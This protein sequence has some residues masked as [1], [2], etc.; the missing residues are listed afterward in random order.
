MVVRGGPGQAWH[1]EGGGRRGE[2]GESLGSS[3]ASARSRTRAVKVKLPTKV[4]MPRPARGA[5]SLAGCGAGIS[6][7]QAECGARAAGA[8][9]GRRSSRGWAGAEEV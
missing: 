2:V 9:A 1:A 8:F 3:E 7:R 6:R 5:P 4:R